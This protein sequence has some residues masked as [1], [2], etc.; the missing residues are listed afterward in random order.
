MISGQ[1]EQQ[2]FE[3]ENFRYMNWYRV[4]GLGKEA[5][6]EAYAK[7]SE[8]GTW[9]LWAGKIEGLKA[10]ACV[11][12]GECEPKCPQNIPIIEQL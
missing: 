3:P 4:W 8:E 11:Q 6:E 10:E 12:C 1:S 2:E 5:E 7:L 9:T